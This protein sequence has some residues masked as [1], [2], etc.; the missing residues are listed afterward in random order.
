MKRKM[1]SVG[2]FGTADVE[3]IPFF[4]VKEGGKQKSHPSSYKRLFTL[5]VVLATIVGSTALI[6]H[7]VP[8]VFHTVP[9]VPGIGD[10]RFLV[11][12][13]D[14]NLFAIL[15]IIILRFYPS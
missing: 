4:E 3:S 6:F 2:S 7:T 15:S 13:S 11:S 9:D 1:N 14:C 12:Y 10:F 8:D 5:F